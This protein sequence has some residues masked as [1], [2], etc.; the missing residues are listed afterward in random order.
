M[1]CPHSIARLEMDDSW[2]SDRLALFFGNSSI[3]TRRGNDL[4]EPEKSVVRPDS[5][6]TEF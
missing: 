5:T 4:Q 1:K 2:T 6:W 3:K